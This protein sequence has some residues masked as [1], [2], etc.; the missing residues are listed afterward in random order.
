MGPGL[1][2]VSSRNRIPLARQNEPRQLSEHCRARGTWYAIHASDNNCKCAT[3]G[4]CYS[5]SGRSGWTISALSSGNAELPV[6]SRKRLGQCQSHCVSHSAVTLAC[7]ATNTSYSLSGDQTVL[8]SALSSSSACLQCAVPPLTSLNAVCNHGALAREQCTGTFAL[9]LLCQLGPT[10]GRLPPHIIPV[11]P[12]VTGSE[13]KF[14]NTGF[15][16]RLGIKSLFARQ[17]LRDGWRTRSTFL[18]TATVATL[19]GTLRSKRTSLRTMAHCTTITR[20]HRPHLQGGNHICYS[21]DSYADCP[22]GGGA[23][24][25]GPRSG[26]ATWCCGDPTKQKCSYS[27]ESSTSPSAKTTHHSRA[28]R[29]ARAARYLAPPRRTPELSAEPT[30]QTPPSPPP[31]PPPPLPPPP[32][33]PPLPPPPVAATVSDTAK[34]ATHMRCG[35]DLRRW[36]VRAVRS[37]RVPGGS[38][39]QRVQVVPNGQVHTIHGQHTASTAR[40]TVVSSR[41]R[42]ATE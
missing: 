10:A 37:G 30:A 14:H 7:S 3:A 12:Q 17:P 28:R 13:L 25:H 39:H 38:L 33:P 22:N 20:A 41:S 1:S 15:H 21:Q 2:T 35:R 36:G 42:L 16:K 18:T 34:P 11:V 27:G 31:T 32:S 6:S 40:P 29:T 26:V 5:F 24:Y 23:V 4:A 9:V 8:T 19:L